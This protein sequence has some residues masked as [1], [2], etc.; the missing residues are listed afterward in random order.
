ML[1]IKNML[2]LFMLS[3]LFHRL[4]LPLLYHCK[5]KFKNSNTCL[6]GQFKNYTPNIQDYLDHDKIPLDKVHPFKNSRKKPSYK[7]PHRQ[8]PPNKLTYHLN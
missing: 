4:N 5:N 6:F 2:L 3:I 7:N 1:I 8:K